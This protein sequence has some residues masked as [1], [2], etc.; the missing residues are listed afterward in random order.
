MLIVDMIKGTLNWNVVLVTGLNIVFC[1][2]ELF[3]SLNL[4]LFYVP[5]MYLL[6][7][8]LS[9]SF[10][11]IWMRSPTWKS[12]I[13]CGFSQKF[14]N[15]Q[16]MTFVT[17]I[18]IPKSIVVCP[19]CCLCIKHIIWIDEIQY[20]YENKL[21]VTFT[22]FLDFLFTDMSYRVRVLSFFCKYFGLIFNINSVNS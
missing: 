16:S 9:S 15:I 4:Y 10:I 5:W 1:F 14:E 20:S 7:F 12:N 6:L 2:V 18:Y 22:D 3:N 19:R 8:A 17:K 11:Y 13:L 21:V